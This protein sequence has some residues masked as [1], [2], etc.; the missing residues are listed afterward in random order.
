[1]CAKFFL[2]V[3]VKMC[4]EC[5]WYPLCN[6]NAFYNYIDLFCDSINYIYIYILYQ[7]YNS[8]VAHQMNF[9][10]EASSLIEQR[11]HEDP[12]LYR[13]TAGSIVSDDFLP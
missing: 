8:F 12:T 13:F 6:F 7:L 4:M 3:K 2:T 1:M 11:N 5:V 10:L 9:I